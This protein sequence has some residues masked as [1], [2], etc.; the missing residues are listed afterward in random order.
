MGVGQAAALAGGISEALITTIAGLFIGIPALVAYNYFAHKAEGAGAGDREILQP[1]AEPASAPSTTRRGGDAVQLQTAAAPEGGHQHHVADR[2][3]LHAAA[4]L[5]DHLHLPGAAG[6]QARAAHRQDRPPTPS[7][8]STCSPSISK[9]GLFLNRQAVALDG[10]EAEI[11]KAL[12][13]MKDGALVLKAD[14]EI[15]HGLVVRVMDLAKRGGVKKLII[16]TK[17]EK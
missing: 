4:V 17:P 15:S 11:R 6:D 5:H 3:H 12:P 13:G 16:G 10:L 14:Q 8:R 2:R 9:G 1:P 7:R